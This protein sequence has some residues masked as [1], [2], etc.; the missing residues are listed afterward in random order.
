MMILVHG[1]VLTSRAY[2]R[3]M[4][5]VRIFSDSDLTAGIPAGPRGA[6]FGHLK[7]REGCG[8]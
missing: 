2:Q 1:R 3:G 6:I 8:A 4:P 5:K 7:H